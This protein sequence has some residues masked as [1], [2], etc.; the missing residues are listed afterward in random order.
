[1]KRQAY[2]EGAAL[3]E[4]RLERNEAL[5]CAHEF[6]GDAQ[7]ETHALRKAATAIG[8]EERNEDFLLVLLR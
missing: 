3:V 1:M 5:V 8:A 2:D 4:L 7:S 6:F